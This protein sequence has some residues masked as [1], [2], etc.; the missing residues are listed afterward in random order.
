[1]EPHHCW[2]NA[3]CYPDRCHNAGSG[4]RCSRVSADG[5]MFCQRCIDEGLS[6]LFQLPHEKEFLAGKTWEDKS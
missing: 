4:L 2:V 5:R 6:E 1:M 3:C